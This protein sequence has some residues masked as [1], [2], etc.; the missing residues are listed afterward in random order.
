VSEPILQYADFIPKRRNLLGP[1]SVLFELLH[2]TLFFALPHL[3]GSG[4]YSPLIVVGAGC[5]T[6][7][8][9]FGIVALVTT[10]ARS[11]TAW[12][13]LGIIAAIQVLRP[14]SSHVANVPP[15]Y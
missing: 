1:L 14:S 5:I 4:W 2:L 15:L 13:A 8:L 9:A 7:A 12:A 3:R 10:R 6:L 11:K